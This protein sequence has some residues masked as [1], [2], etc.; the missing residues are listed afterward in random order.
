MR[1]ARAKI[2]FVEADLSVCSLCEASIPGIHAFLSTNSEM[3]N[4]LEWMTHGLAG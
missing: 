2:C 4:A 1:R 3:Q